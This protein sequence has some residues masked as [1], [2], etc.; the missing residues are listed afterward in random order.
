MPTFTWG[1]IT[2]GVFSV[3]FSKSEA[4]IFSELFRKHQGI[5]RTPNA[6]QSFSILFD[7][8]NVFRELNHENTFGK[9]AIY[10]FFKEN[11][12]W[13]INI[14]TDTFRAST[15]HHIELSANVPYV[16]N[17]YVEFEGIIFDTNNNPHYH[18]QRH[19]GTYIYDGKYT[20][21]K[22][23]IYSKLL[24]SGV[25]KESIYKGMKL[26]YLNNND[27]YEIMLNEI[28]KDPYYLIT[29]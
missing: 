13:I 27:L 16:D 17:H 5:Y 3:N 22:E 28:N 20:W 14:N 24:K 21:N 29:I 19:G 10:D 8:I 15:L 6:I 9:N 18:L 23:K 26:S 7:E 25:L 1:F 12:T 2:T 4:G 11:E